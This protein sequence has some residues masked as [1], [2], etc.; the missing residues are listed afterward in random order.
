[1][2]RQGDLRRHP[3]DE[4]ASPVQIVWKD[5]AGVDRYVSGKSLNISSSGIRVEVAEPIER[6]TYVTLQCAALGV[7]GSASVRSCARKGMKYVVGLEFS[8]GM[9]Y[10]PKS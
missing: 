7:H 1:M 2:S 3:R 4:K 6:Q 8:G 10:K 9:Q 5:R